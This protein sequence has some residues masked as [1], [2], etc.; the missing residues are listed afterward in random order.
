MFVVI[1]LIFQFQTRYYTQVFEMSKFQKVI[2]RVFAFLRPLLYFQYFYY[3]VESWLKKSNRNFFKLNLFK[4]MT[5]G[6]KFGGVWKLQKINDKFVF[7][8][9]NFAF[10]MQV[11]FCHLIFLAWRIKEKNTHRVRAGPSGLEDGLAGLGDGQHGL[12]G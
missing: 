3:I 4:K 12:A 6:W 7:N 2:F 9:H 10:N 5:V 11:I 8:I 1:V